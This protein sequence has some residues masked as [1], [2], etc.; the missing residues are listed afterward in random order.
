MIRMST[1]K[2]AFAQCTSPQV[3]STAEVFL[4]K[5]EAGSRYEHKTNEQ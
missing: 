3:L 1:L 4:V 5:T 2:S